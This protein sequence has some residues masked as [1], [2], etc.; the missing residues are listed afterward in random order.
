MYKKTILILCCL[1]LAMS[2]MA[3]ELAKVPSKFDVI[4]SFGSMAGGPS[5]DV[6]LRSFIK[7]FSR[8]Q[9]VSIVGYKAAG[10]G[11]EG[12]YHILFSLT[13]LKSSVKRKFLSELNASV[14][15]QETKNKARDENSGN[16]SLDYHKNK[17]DFSYCRGG[18]KIW[19]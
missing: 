10:C 3:G 17:S 7:Q 4:V 9:G 8:K 6:F 12:E 2:V 18:I 1:G 13:G 5:S 15:A 14:T 11:R 19:K 16:I